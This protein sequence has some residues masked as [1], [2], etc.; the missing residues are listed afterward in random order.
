M[1]DSRVGNSAL[2]LLA[3]LIACAGVGSA[4][5]GGTPAEAQ[6]TIEDLDFMAGCW[7]ADVG[8]GTTIRE[9]FTA[10][11]G[12]MMLGN[13]QMVGE[14]AT[15]FFELVQIV[16][17]E[18]GV[19]YHPAFDGQKAKVGFRLVRL[20]GQEAVFENPEHDYPQRI[21]YRSPEPGQLQARIELMD[22]EKA[23]GF[24]ME[25]IPCGGKAHRTAL[26]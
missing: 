20:E 24:A 5:E 6:P 13:S 11:H 8:G 3:L 26:Q 15:R 1:F 14:G 19:V 22:G 10:P 9:T 23:Q 12:G 16:G 4:G 7:Q 17:D 21:V 25:A 18:S 2:L